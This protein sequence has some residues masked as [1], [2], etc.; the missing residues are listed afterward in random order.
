MPQKQNVDIAELLRSKVHVMYGYFTQVFIIGLN[1]PSGYNRDLQDTKKPYVEA[2]TLTSDVLRV[3]ELLVTSITPNT[4]VLSS[5]MTK[6]LYATSL[7][8]DYVQQGMAFR[9]AYQNVGE[10]LGKIPQF[11]VQTELRKSSHLG[12]TG[13]LSL[14]SLEKIMQ[15]AHGNVQKQQT[16]WEQ[17]LL[18]LLEI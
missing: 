7:V 13:N 4:K 3:T 11:D 1:L 6:E 5:C 2:I 17:Q 18:S 9:S 12:S 8:Y 16:R 15:Q 14:T 10:N